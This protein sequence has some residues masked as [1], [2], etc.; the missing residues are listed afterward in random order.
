MAGWNGPG[1]WSDVAAA[2]NRQKTDAYKPN[3][4]W[5]APNEHNSPWLK[6]PEYDPELEQQKY[7]QYELGHAA[8]TERTFFGGEKRFDASG[9]EIKDPSKSHRPWWSNLF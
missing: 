9:R 6:R 1:P 7:E 3:P 4:A 2:R 5:S 8:Y